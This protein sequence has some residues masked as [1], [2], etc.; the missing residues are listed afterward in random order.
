MQQENMEPLQRVVWPN[1][2]CV[3]LPNAATSHPFLFLSS[4][5]I[6]IFVAYSLLF[7]SSP[8]MI[9]IFRNFLDSDWAIRWPL[10]FSAKNN[11]C[12]G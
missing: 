3:E 7:L 9:L 6:T 8:P 1:C 5:D 10:L 2:G 12:V 4:S 11:F